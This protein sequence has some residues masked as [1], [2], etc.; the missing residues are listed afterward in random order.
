MMTDKDFLDDPGAAELGC[1]QEPLQLVVY[2]GRSD[3]VMLSAAVSSIFYFTAS[4][5]IHR[6]LGQLG[7]RNWQL[8]G[9]QLFQQL[10]SIPL[11]SA[12]AVSSPS[13]IRRRCLRLVVYLDA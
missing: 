4:G 7:K 10:K 2:M 9:A 8:S 11:R 13:F 1:L 5:V 12:P 6:S 3:S